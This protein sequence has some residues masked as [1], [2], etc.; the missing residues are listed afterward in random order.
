M[1]QF[2]DFMRV[3]TLDEYWSRQP[4]SE[5]PDP[6]LQQQMVNDPAFQTRIKQRLLRRM[7]VSRADFENLPVESKKLLV[8]AA[9][10]PR[11]L[12][13][14]CGL[15]LHPRL[16]QLSI[17][18]DF[19]GVLASGF[20]LDDFAA[21]AE[22]SQNAKAQTAA[23][24]GY[25]PETAMSLIELTGIGCIASCTSTGE[26]S[27]T[28]LFELIYG[29]DYMLAGGQGG[30]QLQNQLTLWFAVEHIA[31]PRKSMAQAA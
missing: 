23:Q 3:L 9:Q 31:R 6:E 10:H 4:L 28:Q 5:L 2:Q 16:V 25:S 21:A 1:N 27:I 29:E 24:P 26:K 18:P 8:I 12:A 14:L 17:Q 22:A 13:L 11:R 7:N 30:D 19:A 20:S 15:V